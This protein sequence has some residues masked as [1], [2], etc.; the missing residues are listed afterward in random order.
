MFYQD[1]CTSGDSL[2]GSA[3]PTPSIKGRKFRKMIQG[4][5]K[6]K[7]PTNPDMKTPSANEEGSMKI[8]CSREREGEN[9]NSVSQK[10]EEK[11]SSGAI[12][13]K[14]SGGNRTRQ[15]AAARHPLRETMTK[16]IRESSGEC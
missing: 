2:K 8:A 11:R 4:G 5:S 14:V 9:V 15:G 3:N 10:K 12:V 6:R 7:E 16:K 13:K 1:R